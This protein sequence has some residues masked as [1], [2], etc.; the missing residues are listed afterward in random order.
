MGTKV[1][2]SLS[3]QDGF[4]EILAS[5]LVTGRITEWDLENNSE[6]RLRGFSLDGSNNPTNKS[7]R[8]ALPKN[9][10]NTN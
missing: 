6:E 5:I 4:H 10:V 7:E 8:K 2:H 3:Y 1:S 9:S